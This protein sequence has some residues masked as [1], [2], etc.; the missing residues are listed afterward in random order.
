MMTSREYMVG[1]PGRKNFLP[2]YTTSPW[3]LN[4]EYFVFFSE[5]TDNSAPLLVLFFPDS[6]KTEQRKELTLWRDLSDNTKEEELLCSVLL[7]ES[8]TMLIPRANT[9]I[10]LNIQNGSTKEVYAAGTEYR[11]GGPLGLS[12]DGKYLC[13]G[14]YPAKMEAGD[15]PAETGVFVFDTHS[16][17]IVFSSVINFFATHFQFFPD[18]RL[19]LF[20]HEGKTETVPDRLNIMDW[21]TGEHHNLYRQIHDADGNLV[22]Y[23]GHEKI[24]GNKVAAVRYPVSQIT[25][26]LI[27]F[28]PVTGNTALVDADDYWHCSS[29]ASGRR[30]VMDTMWWGNASRKIENFSDIILLEPES[31]RKK[32]LKTVRTNPAKQIFHP[33]PQL[34]A[35]GNKVLFIGCTGSDESFITYMTI[36]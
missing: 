27:M 4:D 6:G 5:S 33:H 19:I 16:D 34:N 23:V 12:R 31:G 28:D 11:V 26:G 15:V 17:K 20:C 9:L 22:E 36:E 7:P 1:T 2:Y 10:K 29:N 18:S 35:D 14:L 24:A 32:I 3:G 30:L 25:F 13:G 8:Q 21:H